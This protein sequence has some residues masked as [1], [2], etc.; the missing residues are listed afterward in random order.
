MILLLVYVWLF[1]GGSGRSYYGRRKL[2]A[3]VGELACIPAIAG[4]TS[5][6][7]E[8]MI[9]FADTSVETGLSIILWY[10]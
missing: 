10:M 5:D 6:P 7:A 2:H 8:D 9:A 4:F 3:P 1:L